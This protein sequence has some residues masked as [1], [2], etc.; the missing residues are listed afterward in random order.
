MTYEYLTLPS[1]SL[2]SIIFSPPSRLQVITGAGLPVAAHLNVTLLP[3]L[4]IISVLVGKSKMSGGT[5]TN[6]QNSK[7]RIFCE[8]FFYSQFRHCTNQQLNYKK[9]QSSKNYY[10][11]CLF[12]YTHSSGFR[13]WK[14][15]D[16]RVRKSGNSGNKMQ[17][18]RFSI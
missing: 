14:K 6:K 1:V 7:F 2:E 12:F 9:R 8:F 10:Y 11:Y 15:T 17:I 3:S 16:G 5:V 13:N 4:T 18:F